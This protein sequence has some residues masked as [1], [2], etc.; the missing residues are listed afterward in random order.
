MPASSNLDAA[1]Q[2]VRGICVAQKQLLQPSIQL[3][4]LPARV[5]ANSTRLAVPLLALAGDEMR[6][7]NGGLESEFEGSED[8]R[9]AGWDLVSCRIKDLVDRLTAVRDA[10]SS[11]KQRQRTKPLAVSPHSNR[12][13]QPVSASWGGVSLYS[14]G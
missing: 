8:S 6:A 11:R 1:L 13:D 9:A 4:I 14:H 7:R 2:L 12:C 5:H 3:I 10:P